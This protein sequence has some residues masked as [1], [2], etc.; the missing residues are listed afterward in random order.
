MT[1]RLGPGVWF[2][3]S[4]RGR[5]SYP[6]TREGWMVV[7]RFALGMFGSGAAGWLVGNWATG[8]GIEL[9]E[10]AFPAIFTIGAIASVWYLA[11]TARKHTDYTITVSDYMASRDSGK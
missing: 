7:A 6:V 5:G 4:D 2:V 10:F 1:L 11:T 8:Q 3:R 9:G